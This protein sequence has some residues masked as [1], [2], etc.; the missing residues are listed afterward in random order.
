MSLAS[1]LGGLG[2]EYPTH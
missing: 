2:Q 1:F